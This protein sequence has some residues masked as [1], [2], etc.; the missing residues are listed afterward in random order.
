MEKC[1]DFMLRRA[2]RGLE[3]GG[4]IDYKEM[5]MVLGCAERWQKLKRRLH[6]YEPQCGSDIDTLR[7]R[8]EAARNGTLPAER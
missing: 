8:I 5:S 4:R 7:K 2:A 6:P 1:M 3:E